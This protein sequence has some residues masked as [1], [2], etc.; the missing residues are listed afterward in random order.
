MICVR[1]VLDYLYL[2]SCVVG[3]FGESGEYK[4]YTKEPK[5]IKS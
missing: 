2:Q 4:K 5:S 1:F 3:H